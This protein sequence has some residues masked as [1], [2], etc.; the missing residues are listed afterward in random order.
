MKG[1]SPRH[2][3][4]PECSPFGGGLRKTSVECLSLPLGGGME[5]GQLIFG[6]GALGPFVK[7]A[8]AAAE[9][10]TDPIL[11]TLLSSQAEGAEPSLEEVSV[12]F[13]GNTLSAKDK[14]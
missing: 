6:R 11:P 5:G 3:P 8:S 1:G 4:L 13:C 7:L 12:G 2:P 10:F 14:S 9:L